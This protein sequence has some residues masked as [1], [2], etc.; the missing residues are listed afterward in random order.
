M[1][2]IVDA[3]LRTSLPGRPVGEPVQLGWP[4]TDAGV[5]LARRL[6]EAAIEDP[7][8]EAVLVEGTT[9]DRLVDEAQVAQAE[10][11]WE[12]LEADRGV[13]ELAADTFHGHAQDVRMVEGEGEG[14]ALVRS[15]A[16]PSP[17]LSP[18]GDREAGEDEAFVAVPGSRLLQ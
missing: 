13:I 8:P 12:E 7:A 1:R 9:E 16:D 10:A 18:P 15:G 5:A 6:D 4:V 3:S 11:V 2:A 14:T 17:G